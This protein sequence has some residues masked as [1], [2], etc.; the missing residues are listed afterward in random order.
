[1]PNTRL[2]KE[3]ETRE[4]PRQSRSRGW[5]RLQRRNAGGKGGEKGKQIFMAFGVEGTPNMFPSEGASILM[6]CPFT[7]LVTTPSVT[8]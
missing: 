6:P 5:F 7:K 8:L 3:E 4:Q 2:I 1:M